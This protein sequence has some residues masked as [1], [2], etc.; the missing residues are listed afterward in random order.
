MKSLAVLAVAAVGVSAQNIVS[1]DTFTITQ[2]E[3]FA[4]EIILDIHL[5]NTIIA[6]EVFQHGCYC[7]KMYSL[8]EKSIRGGNTV[9]DDFDEICRS[10]SRC[11]ECNDKHVGGSCRDANVN[12]RDTDYEYVIT[13]NLYDDG[14][15]V[16]D[17]TANVEACA[18]D[19]CLIDVEYINQ[20]ANYLDQFS[21]S[22]PFAALAI[23]DTS[24]PHLNEPYQERTCNGTAPDLFTVKVDNRVVATAEEVLEQFSEQL[25]DQIVDDAVTAEGIACQD[26]TC[27]CSGG[28]ALANVLFFR[29][30]TYDTWHN[31]KALCESMG[32]TLAEPRTAAE[33]N[34]LTTG[35]PSS[36]IGGRRQPYDT[37]TETWDVSDPTYNTWVWDTDGALASPTHWSGGEPNNSGGYEPCMQMYT[38]GR[39]NDLGCNYSLQIVCQQRTC[40]GNE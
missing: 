12:P 6:N 34:L 40:N 19:S 24:C 35:A 7:S 15:I 36:Y 29:T 14:A 9:V 5:N 38:S 1:S 25:S 27:G 17:C 28:E 26:G 33:N 23:N 4:P 18:Y 3:N 20:I 39:W 16:Y 10:W 11:R 31:G 37:V 13:Q 30:T 32:M 2:S 22:T 8:N 21:E